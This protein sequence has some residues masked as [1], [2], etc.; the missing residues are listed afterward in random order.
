MKFPD[1]PGVYLFKNG[2][3]RVIYVGKAKSL[4]NR[5]S[6]YFKSPQ[7]SHK[8]K[9]LISE[10]KNI[11]F[12]VTPTELEALLLERK[13]IKKYSPRFNVVW[14]DDKQYP[15]LKVTLNEEWPRLIIARKKEN[16]IAEYFGPYLSISVKE[17]MLLIKRMFPIRWC[18]ES[19]LK[20]RAQ[21]CLHYHLKHCWAPCAGKISSDEYLKM[22]DAIIGILRGDIVYTIKSLTEEMETASKKLNYELAA[23]IRNRI[24]N[25]QKMREKKPDW[26]PKKRGKTGD[27]SA[28]ELKNI[29]NLKRT[30]NRIEAFDVSNIQGEEIVASMVAFVKGE[31]L[32]RDYRKFIIRELKEQN[33]VESIYQC[34][35]RRYKGT[36]KMDQPDLILVDGGIAQ[37]RAAQKALI[38]AENKAPVIGLAKKQE[39]IF[40]PEVNRP[41]KLKIDNPALLL[42]MRIRDEAHRF[43]NAFNRQRRRLV[44]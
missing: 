30:P 42:L 13:L 10:Y 8:T 29:L 12:I 33:D 32:K 25:L 38:K 16:D 24:R 6:S 39:E 15:Y 14:R 22:I 35:L 27:T 9:S 23:K 1:Q 5:V 19:P 36:L 28:W 20:K 11:D 37:A 17:T 2:D 7:D 43:A 3:G 40:L 26:A 21:P 4:K 18:K 44:K 41:I 34:V 31:P